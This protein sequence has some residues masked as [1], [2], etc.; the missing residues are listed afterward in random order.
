MKDENYYIDLI[1]KH[2]SGSSNLGLIM[3]PESL[4][5]LSK[6]LN[7]QPDIKAQIIEL[8][9]GE[10]IKAKSEAVAYQDSIG[11]FG[12]EARPF[13]S[14]LLSSTLINIRCLADLLTKIRDI[15]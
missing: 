5:E 6:E 4:Q 2:F 10:I 12:E 9:E 7:N 11:E 14:R 13:T 15:K 3:S 8:V 1:S